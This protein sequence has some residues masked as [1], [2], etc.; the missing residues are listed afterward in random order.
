MAE[1]LTQLQAEKPVY[2]GA[3]GAHG[4]WTEVIRRTAIGAGADIRGL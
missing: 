4:W 3:D 1:A 2:N